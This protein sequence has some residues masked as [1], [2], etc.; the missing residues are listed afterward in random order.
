MAHDV[1]SLRLRYMYGNNLTSLD[2]DTFSG[3]PSLQN[4]WVS[5]NFLWSKKPSQR[6]SLVC[7]SFHQSLILLYSNQRHV[8]QSAHQHCSWRFRYEQRGSWQSVSFYYWF[9]CAERHSKWS[10]P[11]ITFCPLSFQRPLRQPDYLPSR[12]YFRFIF[13]SWRY[14]GFLISETNEDCHNWKRQNVFSSTYSLPSQQ[15]PFPQQYHSN[16]AKHT[17]RVNQYSM[18]VS[19]PILPFL[20]LPPSLSLFQPSFPRKKKN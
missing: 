13:W 16:P 2:T 11:V 14:V 10:L 1:V 6:K 18:H 20:L 3:L 15:G 4:L 9:Y 8:K 7:F 12:V 17:Y 5:E 19:V